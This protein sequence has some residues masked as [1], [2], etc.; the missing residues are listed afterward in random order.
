[1]VDAARANSDF[2]SIARMDDRFRV[3][4][5]DREH[6]CER[7]AGFFWDTST[8]LRAHAMLTTPFCY[9]PPR[10]LSLIS[11]FYANSGTLGRPLGCR[12][13]AD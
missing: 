9:P 6:F 12:A 2:G 5:R 11:Y 8:V 3:A 4:N 7:M 1:M 10:I 13:D